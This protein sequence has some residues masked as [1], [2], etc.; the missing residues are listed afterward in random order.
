LGQTGGANLEGGILVDGSKVIRDT[1]LNIYFPLF[2]VVTAERVLVI[3]T[4]S[5]LK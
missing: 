2:L 1:N 3:V 5:S 4:A